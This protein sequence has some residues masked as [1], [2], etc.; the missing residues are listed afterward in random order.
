M[1]T[2]NLRS[3][4]AEFFKDL[5]LPDN[6]RYALRETP[7]PILSGEDLIS[8]IADAK[9]LVTVGDYCT[10]YVLDRGVQPNIA[11]VDFKTKRMEN[12]DY[13]ES[14]GSFGDIVKE[15][16]NPPAIITKAA[17]L[18]IYEAFKSKKRVRVD[19][20]GEEDLLTLVC[21]ALAPLGTVVLYGLPGRGTVVV[22]VKK[23]VKEK[24]RKI[25]ERM[26]G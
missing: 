6:L 13:V 7:G 21:I 25:L 18:T 22:H 14:L 2:A 20:N 12:I 4:F 19:I 8:A 3:E 26:V 15:V 23:E 1:P 11:I 16:E 9:K 5:R 24:V 17:W 10:K